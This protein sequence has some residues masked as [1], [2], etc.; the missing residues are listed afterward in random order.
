MGAAAVDHEKEGNLPVHS[1]RRPVAAG[2]QVVKRDEP[3]AFLCVVKRGQTFRIPVPA[4][5]QIPTHAGSKSMIDRCIR[6]QP[7]SA[8]DDWIFSCWVTQDNKE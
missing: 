5:L 4:F 6:G 1:Q 7:Y 8:K 2:R 3:G